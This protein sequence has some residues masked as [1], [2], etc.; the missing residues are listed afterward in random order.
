MTN[1]DIEK[2]IP[3]HILAVLDRF[4]GAGEDAYA[5]GGCIRDI[6]LSRAIGDFDITSS[7]LPEKTALLFSD[8]RVIETGIRHGTLTVIVETEP[9]E[10]TT[11]RIDGDY[12]DSRH[13]EEVTF[14]R[15]IEDDLSRRD[16]TVNAMAFSPRKGLVDPFGGRDD[17]SA[18][19][20]RA[21]GEPKKRFTE[22]AL[23][24]MRAFR[25]AATL[26]F[27]IEENTLLAAAVCKEGLKN[28]ARERIGVEFIKL[29]LAP[30]PKNILEKMRDLGIL[31]YVTDGYCPQSEI[32]A[33]LSK[34]P[35][36]EGA[37]LGLF[38][39]GLS[40]QRAKEI[41]SSLKRSGI[42]TKSALA[43]IRGAERAVS[44]EAEARRLIGEC[45]IYAKN[46][47]IA[48]VLLGNSPAQAIKWVSENTAPCTLRDLAIRGRD[49][50]DA[51]FE[52]REVGIA[53]DAALAAVIKDPSMNE[54][55][56]LIAY[57]TSRKKRTGSTAI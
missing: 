22:D 7:A 8:K 25:F 1:A 9:V 16:F 56:K 35:R 3:S 19:M 32:L 26:D 44:D 2:H 21:V 38:L 42:V 31:Q 15:R 20:I 43:T 39:S 4:Y 13:P 34:M 37:R 27:E 10:I 51:G 55:D 23:R 53:L 47:V 28:I 45:G 46:A 40:A 24:I 41:L 12:K 54:K 5:V 50:M 57:C 11:F 36:D 48:S 17:L 18:R 14:T 29:L 6:L 52:G 49:L 33:L 30:D